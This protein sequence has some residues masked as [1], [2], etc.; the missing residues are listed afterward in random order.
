MGSHLG[1]WGNSSEAEVRNANA[2][3]GRKEKYLH[4]PL[5]VL[6]LVSTYTHSTLLSA[7]GVG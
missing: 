1:V 3:E 2:M 4:A 5:A 7:A 6:S